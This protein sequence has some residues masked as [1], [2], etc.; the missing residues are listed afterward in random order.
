MKPIV[1]TY[2]GV[3]Y[4]S[5]TEARWA[6]FFDRI[7]MNVDYEAFE[8]DIPTIGKYTP[9]F[10]IGSEL[11][12]EVKPV[13]PTGL[14]V[15]KARA[16]ARLCNG[17]VLLI[18]QPEYRCYWMLTFRNGQPGEVPILLTG[19]PVVVAEDWQTAKDGIPP[20]SFPVKYRQAVEDARHARFDGFDSYRTTIRARYA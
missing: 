11:F 18:G 3:T 7:G 10:S 17:V 8:L 19:T 9:D 16:L 15:S 1:T 2:N 5:R 13:W 12:A 14:E 4:R 20:D 6:V